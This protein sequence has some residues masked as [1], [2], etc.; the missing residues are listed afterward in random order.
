MTPQIGK[1]AERRLRGC[2]NDATTDRIRAVV[3]SVSVV[4][5]TAAVTSSS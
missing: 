2:I 3:R 5:G 4:S 1:Y